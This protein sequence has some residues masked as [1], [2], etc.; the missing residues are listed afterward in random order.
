M[1]TDSIQ[2]EMARV[3]MLI[4]EYISGRRD[5]DGLDTVGDGPCPDADLRRVFQDGGMETDS[6]QSEMA[7]VQMLISDVYFRTAGWRRTRY[8]RR[9]P[10][11]RC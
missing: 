10:V 1:E 4:T 5:G 2:S 6:I 11:S 9:W 7:R 8:S 3:Q